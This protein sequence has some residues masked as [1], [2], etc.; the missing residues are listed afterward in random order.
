M[1]SF[2]RTD[3]GPRSPDSP[4]P[5]DEPERLQVAVVSGPQ[6]RCHP[7]LIR[8]V[9][10]L[11]CGLLQ[12]VQVAVPGRPV[13]PVVHGGAPRLTPSS[14]P[15]RIWMSLPPLFG[16]LRVQDAAGPVERRGAGLTGWLLGD[17][18]G[19]VAV[20]ERGRC[21]DDVTKR[22]FIYKLP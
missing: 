2:C 7:I 9:Q 21:Y 1:L 14:V 4:P 11:P 17:A 20:V 6:G 16:Q 15:W 18:N 22:P 13:V 3:T 10:L 8:C 19:G 5:H 12:H